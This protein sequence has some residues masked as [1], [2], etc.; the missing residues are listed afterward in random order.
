MAE[1]ESVRPAVSTASV[2]INDAQDAIV[3]PSRIAAARPA[4]IPHQASTAAIMP[5]IATA[6]MHSNAIS[7][8]RRPLKTV[9]LTTPQPMRPT[10]LP[11]WANPMAILAMP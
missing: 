2:W 8:L 1:P 6:A 4:P 9:S 11:H 7:F 3:R 5:K 10:A